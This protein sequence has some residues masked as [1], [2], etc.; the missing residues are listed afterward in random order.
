MSYFY[1]LWK[2]QKTFPF[3]KR[4]THFMLLVSFYTPW[5]HQKTCSFLFSGGGGGR[6]RRGYRKRPMTW[7]RLKSKSSS[8]F[9]HLLNYASKWTKSTNE[10]IASWENLN[11]NQKQNERKIDTLQYHNNT[12][13]GRFSFKIIDIVFG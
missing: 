5:K 7:N 12:L 13:R 6:G 9:A 8:T 4:L 11:Q 3:S 1:T 2:R 10:F